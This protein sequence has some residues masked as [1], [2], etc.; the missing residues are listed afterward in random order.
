MQKLPKTPRN[1]AAKPR[2][3]AGASST[4]SEFWSVPPRFKG[5]TIFIIAGGPSVTQEAVD[6]LRGRPVIT[7]NSS[8]EKAPW[9]DYVF[10]MDYRWLRHN[11]RR[12]R[13]EFAG[14]VVSTSRAEY[15]PGLLRLRRFLKPGLTHKRDEVAGRVTSLTCA[16]NLA[17]HLG[18]KAIVLLGADGGPAKDGRTH[19]HSPHPWK[20]GPKAYEKQAAE[21][22]QIV[23]PLKKLGIRI[24]NTSTKT[25]WGYIFPLMELQSFLRSEG[26]EM[27]KSVAAYRD[28]FERERLNVYPQMDA[29]EAA[30]DA[31]IKTSTLEAMARVLA[32]PLKVNPPNWQ[33]GRLLYALTTRYFKNHPDQSFHFVDIGTAKGF[34]ALCLAHALADA[35]RQGVITSVDV[36]DPLRAEERNSVIELPNGPLPLSSYVENFLPFQRGTAK[37]FDGSLIISFWKNVDIYFHKGAGMLF[38]HDLAR[39]DRI[40]V[41]FVDGKHKQTDVSAESAEI[42]TRQF[43]G[44]LIIFDDLQLDPVKTA[45]LKLRGYHIEYVDP[46]APIDLIKGDWSPAR[47]QRCYAIAT[48]L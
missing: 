24:V 8:F 15:W 13:E 14:R 48:K 35:G 12:L 44:D 46:A 31:K 5:R 20:V 47:P 22:A 18:A 23:D 21:L 4:P 36:I 16:I 40:N 7:V 25:K 17:V 3:K 26:V 33:H 30:C 11:R 39:D 19:H 38:L 10:G 29:I 45:V 32:C 43:P 34:S 9:C 2:S 42:R 28:I 37:A 41:A 6:S 27:E 1:A